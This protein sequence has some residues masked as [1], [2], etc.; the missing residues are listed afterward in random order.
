M[1]C[2]SLSKKS[3]KSHIRPDPN[4]SGIQNSVSEKPDHYMGQTR[5]VRTRT[6]DISG[7]LGL[8]EIRKPFVDTLV[9]VI[10][11]LRQGVK[12]GEETYKRINFP[13]I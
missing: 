8:P 7:I 9:Q 13:W 11:F 6:S 3:E 5:L 4:F 1:L 12:K 10:Q 2:S